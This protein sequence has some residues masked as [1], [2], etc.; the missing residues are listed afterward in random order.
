MQCMTL[1]FSCSAYTAYYSRTQRDVIEVRRLVADC[2]IDA[3]QQFNICSEKFIR[4]RPDSSYC[5]NMAIIF[6]V[7][8]LV[9]MVHADQLISIVCC[10]MEMTCKYWLR[11]IESA[12]T[13]CSHY[14]TAIFHAF[15][16]DVTDDVFTK[17]SQSPSSS[18]QEVHIG[19]PDTCHLILRLLADLQR[20][21]T[22]R[23]CN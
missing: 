10:T 11:D 7:G 21:P 17:Q 23:H 2:I 4:N 9:G 20:R 5:F 3:I 14:H 6:S 1:S 19:G 22:S 8:L 12:F 16:V 15:T 13:T 18:V